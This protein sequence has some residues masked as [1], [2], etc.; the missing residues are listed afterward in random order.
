[1]QI[2]NDETSSFVGV[3]FSTCAPACDS[4]VAFFTPDWKPIAFSLPK[5]EA[6]S[7]LLPN[8]SADNLVLANGL[9]SPLFVHYSF[10]KGTANLIATCTAEKFLAESD[11]KQLKPLLKQES[12]RFTFQK[13]G[14]KEQK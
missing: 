3:I 9:L 6:S 10:Q 5:V 7:Y 1:M 12:I 8:L 14:W 13:D 11:W 4:Q 2:F